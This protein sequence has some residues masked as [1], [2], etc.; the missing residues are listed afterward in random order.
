FAGMLRSLSYAAYAALL[1]VAEPD[2]DDWQR[3][4]PWAR[5]WEL[6]ARS[7]F[8]NAYMSRSHEGHFLPP[9][10]EDL[11]LL[12][13]IFEIDKAL[14]EIKYERSHRPDWLRIPLRGLSQVIERGE[15]R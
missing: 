12:L 10:R 11:L 4:E 5:D 13:D 3:L 8:A 14:Y 7:R 1:E 15:T 6:L 2:S 9:E